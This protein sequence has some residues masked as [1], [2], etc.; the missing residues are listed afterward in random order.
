MPA[1]EIVPYS[2]GVKIKPAFHIVQLDLELMF[3]EDPI[4]TACK[5]DLKCTLMKYICAVNEE[6][7]SGWTRFNTMLYNHEIPSVPELDICQLL[8]LHQLNIEP[9]T[10]SLYKAKK[11]L[12]NWN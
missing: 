2:T 8:M 7:I 6:V 12:I 1:S 5:H 4:S 11:L 10:Q 3:N 9:P